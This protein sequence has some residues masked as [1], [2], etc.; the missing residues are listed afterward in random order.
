MNTTTQQ[1]H[2]SHRPILAKS[3]WRGLSRKHPLTRIKR[4]YED[5]N[6]PLP[7][8]RQMRDIFMAIRSPGAL[9]LEQAELEAR[10]LECKVQLFRIRY[11]MSRLK[12]YDKYYFTLSK[13]ASVWMRNLHNVNNHAKLKGREETARKAV[14][15]TSSAVHSRADDEETAAGDDV[16]DTT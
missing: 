14:P 1:H 5:A 7:V 13:A 3:G 12:P 4:E 11:E 6:L 2:R 16:A 9:T 15:I 8:L 10:R